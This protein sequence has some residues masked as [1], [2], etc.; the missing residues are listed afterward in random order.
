MIFRGESELT[1]D[2]TAPFLAKSLLL[3]SLSRLSIENSGNDIYEK[4]F[5][6]GCYN[7][8]I[9]RSRATNSARAE[10][11]S[12]RNIR[13]RACLTEFCVIQSSTPISTFVNPFATNSAIC[14]SRAVNPCCPF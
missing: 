11:L 13:L 7:F 9:C 5:R 10:T 8:S 4:L 14:S 6:F 1:S 3:I 12:F 2:T